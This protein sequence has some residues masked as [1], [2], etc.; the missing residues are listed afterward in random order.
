M[1][2]LWSQAGLSVGIEPVAPWFAAAS[3]RDWEFESPDERADLEA[4]WDPV[5]GDRQNELVFIGVDMDE[6][7]IR[8]RL[9][10]CIVTGDEFAAG[11]ELWA[12]F[13][14]PL[15]EWDLSCEL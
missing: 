8:A 1:Q 9:D 5:V 11:P 15:P 6:A 12:T 3:E 7:D 10:R 4:R 14:D 13:S 2:A